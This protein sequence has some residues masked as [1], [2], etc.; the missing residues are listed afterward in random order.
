MNFKK[1]DWV[2]EENGYPSGN[3]YVWE[4][5]KYINPEY[6]LKV[7]ARIINKESA[8]FYIGS[9]RIKRLS[10]CKKITR[11]EVMLEML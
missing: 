4:V 7:V 8:A 2:F 10:G 5:I 9:L 6:K 3:K 11:E 1:G